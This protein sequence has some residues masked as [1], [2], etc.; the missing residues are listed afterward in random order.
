MAFMG[1][2]FGVLIL[3]ALDEPERVGQWLYR[4]RYGMAN[5]LYASELHRLRHKKN[6]GIARR[7]AKAEHEK[8]ARE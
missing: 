2:V 8:G 6:R 3:W 4:V 1:I 5:S 7:R